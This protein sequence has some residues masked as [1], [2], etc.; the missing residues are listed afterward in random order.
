MARY[1]LDQVMGDIDTADKMCW[2][3][4]VVDGKK[5]G[6]RD[7]GLRGFTRPPWASGRSHRLF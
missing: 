1:Y 5:Q 7:R 2:E 4:G 6:A 3:G